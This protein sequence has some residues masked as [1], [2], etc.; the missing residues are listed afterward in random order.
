MIAEAAALAAVTS[1]VVGVIGA[2]L[3]RWTSSR[4]LALAAAI[5]PLVVLLSVA[6]GTMIAARAMFISDHDRQV[7]LIVTGTCLPVAAFFGWLIARQVQRRARRAAE[8]AAELE[9]DRRVEADRREL[10]A[11]LSHDLR[12]PLAGIRAMAEAMEDG[13]AT[14]ELHYP[15][16]IRA[17]ADRMAAMIS[18]LLSLA[19]LQ[20]ESVQLDRT[21]VDLRDLVSDAL[22]SARI[23]ADRKRIRVTG[24]GGDAVV[25]RVDAHEVSRALD[26]LVANAV[27]HT[28][29]G[30]EIGVDLRADHDGARVSVTDG[31]G[32]IP[33]GDLPHVF[34]TGWRGDSGRTPAD[35]QGTGLGLTVARAIARAHGGDLTVANVTGGCRF[36]LSLPTGRPVV[37][38]G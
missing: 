14:V 3:V 22:A 15:S 25:A 11:W 7:M 29:D 2:L 38:A 36:E 18:Q 28:P 37:A 9:R 33:Q 24:M 10:V 31:C 13:V 32:G 35:D 23:L 27:T 6:I 5:A 30:G 26:N 12:T 1:V 16:R 21:E 17:E 34:D 20:S 8:T 4:S 19:R